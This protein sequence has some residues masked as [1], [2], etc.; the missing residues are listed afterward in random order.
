MA[1]YVYDD[2]RVT[3]TPRPDGAYDMVAPDATGTAITGAF[4]PPLSGDDLERAVARRARRPQLAT[5]RD[6]GVGEPRTVDPEHLGAALA[7][8]LFAGPVGAAYD[9]RGRPPRRAGGGCDCHCRWPPR[10]HC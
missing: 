4:R 3:F 9:R 6:V 5:T 7:E 10:R 1:T 2:F 8:A